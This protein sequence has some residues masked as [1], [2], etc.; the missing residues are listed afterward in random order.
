MKVFRYV[1]QLSLCLMILTL[2]SPNLFSQNNCNRFEFSLGG[3]IVSRYIF[4]GV[5]FGPNP[6]TPHIQPHFGI[7]YRF[8]Q[9][10]SVKIGGWASYG[11]SNNFSENDLSLN[12]THSIEKAGSF[13]LTLLDLYFPYLGVDFNNFDDKGTGA[14]FIGL[15]FDYTGASSFPVTFQAAS[16]VYNDFPGNKSLYLEL[17]Y[18]FSISNVNGKLFFG[19]A[20]GKSQWNTI[21]TDKFEFDN[22][23]LSLSKKLKITEDYSVPVGISYILNWHLKTSYL[24]LKLSV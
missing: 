17:G 12:Y 9:N 23:G 24:V 16:L 21:R 14:H 18:M 22:I 15:Q 2:C 5:E 3:D 20:Q 19:A 11:I 7:T 4:R 1:F 8:S 13:S 6:S 10:S